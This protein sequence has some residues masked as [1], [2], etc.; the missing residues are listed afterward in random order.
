MQKNSKNSAYQ[1]F[2]V[3]YFQIEDSTEARIVLKD[4]MLSLP[5]DELFAFTKDTR[6]ELV[7]WF[8]ST[9]RTDAEK[10]HFVQHLDNKMAQ[11]FQKAA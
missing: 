8:R 9:E 3:R 7:T 10:Q 4:F 6:Q 5:T 11:Y 2:W 1:A